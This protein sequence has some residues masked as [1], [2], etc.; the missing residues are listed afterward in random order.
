MRPLLADRSRLLHSFFVVLLLLPAC[1][2]PRAAAQS[3]SSLISSLLQ[4]RLQT[5]PVVA[6]QLRRV[7]GA[8]VPALRVPRESAEWDAEAERLHA[9][10]L[11]VLY[12]GWPQAWVDA[13]PKFEQVGAI[14]GR[15]YRIRKLR[16]EVVPGM[17]SAALLYEPEHLSGKVPAVLNVHGHEPQ[18]KAAEYKQKRCINEARRGILALNLE[19]FAFG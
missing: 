14:E 7:M 19:W 15:G 8:R 3:D 18:G 5:E 2:P 4:Q 13:P 6:E 17:Y 1:T 12:H 16:Y 11:A 10:E 9:R